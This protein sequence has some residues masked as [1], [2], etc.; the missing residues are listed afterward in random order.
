[1]R[2]WVISAQRYRLHDLAE[3]STYPK[4]FLDHLE[5]SGIERSGMFSPI[6]D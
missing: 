5:G 6:Y 2:S 4:T 3:V 1:M